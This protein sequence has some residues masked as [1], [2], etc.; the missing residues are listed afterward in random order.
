MQP[1][2]L[3]HA[4]SEEKE[5][6]KSKREMKGKAKENERKRKATT[7]NIELKSDV[8]KVGDMINFEVTARKTK[9]REIESQ[10]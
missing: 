9:E 10:S 5:L 4:R 7:E 6:R 1:H 3:N 2:D 8:G